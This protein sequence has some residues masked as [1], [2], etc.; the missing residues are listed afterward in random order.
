MN[1]LSGKKLL[2]IAGGTEQ[3]NTIQWAVEQGVKAY[4]V[5][6]SE[7]APAFPYATARLTC[8]IGDRKRIL[9]FAKKHA[10]DGVTSICLESTMHTTAYI[11]DELK[12]PGLSQKGAENV[13]NKYRMRTLF[14]KAGLPVP[15]Y[16]L[17]TPELLED[18]EFPGFDGP[19]VIK[20]VDNAGSRGVR[21]VQ[22]R[23]CFKEAYR[24]ALKFSR[25]AEVL[26][27]EFV[28]GREISVEGYVIKGNLFVETLSDKRRSPLPYLFDLNVTFPSRYPEHVQ[29]EAVRQ[30]RN[31]VEALGIRD[32]PVHAELMVTKGEKIFIVEIAG[33]GPGSNVYTEIIPH[34]SGVYPSRLQVLSALN[35]LPEHINVNA[36]LRGATLHFFTS[37]ARRRIKSFIGLDKLRGIPDVFECR[38]YLQVGDIIEK[39][40]SGEQRF[41]Q[42]I[43]LSETLEEAIKVQKKALKLIKVELEA[44]D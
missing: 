2:F 20:P 27:E 41:G 31:A 29:Q 30:I 13:T 25:R 34:V 18:D 35:C 38:F 36:P 4:V 24:D 22:D 5:D 43:T 32:G 39:C 44:V 1:N 17:I 8:N 40:V 7:N 37:R 21:M 11:V 10:I 9:E 16:H 6:I 26:I 14:E 19:W 28:P 3:V 33:R 23:N 42:L 12:L 15:H